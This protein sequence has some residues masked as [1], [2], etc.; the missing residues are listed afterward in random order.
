M[1]VCQ[2]EISLRHFLRQQQAVMLQSLFFAQRLK[3]LLS[4]HLAQC[5]WRING[6]VN[7]DVRNVDV[8]IRELRV[9]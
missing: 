4:Q 9:Q 6:T 2:V 1:L 8:L 3:L 5:V 7:Q